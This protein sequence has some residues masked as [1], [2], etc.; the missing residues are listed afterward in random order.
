MS[1]KL[2]F[3]FFS[4]LRGVLT[5]NQAWN[6]PD[7]ACEPS[8]AFCNAQMAANLLDFEIDRD[9]IFSQINQTWYIQ[10]NFYKSK[11]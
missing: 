11:F 8:S 2:T 5:C 1:K 7:N 10:L 6:W 4:M 3:I 9:S